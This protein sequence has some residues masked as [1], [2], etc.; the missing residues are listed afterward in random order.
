MLRPHHLFSQVL[1]DHVQCLLS[2]VILVLHAVFPAASSSKYLLHNWLPQGIH[3]Q[4]KIAGAYMQSNKMRQGGT[5]RAGQAVVIM[6]F[7]MHTRLLRSRSSTS[8]A[9]SGQAY[10]AFG[11]VQVTA[12]LFP[13]IPVHHPLKPSRCH[14]ASDLQNRGA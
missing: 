9:C 11:M 14:F 3:C 7:L 1:H 8:K 13:L 2:K 12:F 4:A 10:K 5:N 6:R